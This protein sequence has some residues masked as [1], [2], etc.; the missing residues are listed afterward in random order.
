MDIRLRITEHI[1]YMSA[2]RNANNILVGKLQGKRPFG[3]C[4]QMRG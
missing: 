4:I 3:D 2:M 1:A